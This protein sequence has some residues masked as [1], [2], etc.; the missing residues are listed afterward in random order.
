M[1]REFSHANTMMIMVMMLLSYDIIT[2]RYLIQRENKN[3]CNCDNRLAIHTA[4]SSD[5]S[6]SRYTNRRFTS[7]I[8]Q[9]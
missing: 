6:S 2:F 7:E 3:K 4:A 1:R 5:F 8:L 9:A